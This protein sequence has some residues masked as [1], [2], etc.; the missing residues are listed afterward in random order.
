VTAIIGAT[1]YGEAL[2]VADLAGVLLIC[3]AIVLIRL[4]ARLE[5]RAPGAHVAD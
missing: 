2:T 1:V 4:P 3:S 5:S